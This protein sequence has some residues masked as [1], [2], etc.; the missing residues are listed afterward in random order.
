MSQDNDNSKAVEVLPETI[1]QAIRVWA[2]RSA[3][4][5]ALLAPGRTSLTYGRLWKQIENIVGWLNRM[6]IGRNDLVALMVPNGPEMA[7]AILGIASGAAVTPINTAF[8]SEELERIFSDLRIRALVMQAGL[9]SPAGDLARARSIQVVELMPSW[10]AEAGIFTLSGEDGVLAASAGICG[11]DDICR[12][13][14]T[15]G[16][17]GRPKIITHT[18]RHYSTRARLWDSALQLSQTDRC[19]NLMPLIYGGGLMNGLVATLYAGGSVVCPPA[20]HQ[21]SFFEWLEC[22]HP[23]YYTGSPTIHRAVLDQARGKQ[24]VI[25]RCPLRFIGATSAVLPSHLRDQLEAVFNA[26]VFEMYSS[27]E[28]GPIAVSPLSPKKR[29]PGSVGLP[30]GTEVAIMSEPGS[31]LPAG[32]IGEIVVRGPALFRG[33]QNDPEANKRSFVGGWFRMGDLGYLDEEGYL[34]LTGRLKEII[35]SGGQKVSPYEVN[36]ALLAHSAVAEAEAFAVPH[37][38]LGEEVAAAVVLR[39]GVVASERELREFTAGRLTRFKVPR[40]VLI[41]DEIPKSPAG[42]IQRARLAEWFGKTAGFGNENIAEYVRPRTRLEEQLAQIWEEVLQIKRVGVHDDFQSLGG[43]SIQATLIIGMACELFGISLPLDQFFKASTIAQMAEIVAR[44]KSGKSPAVS[45]VTIRGGGSKPPLFW[46]HGAEGTIFWYNDLVQHLGQDQPVY[47]VVPLGLNRT[48]LRP[49]RL[50]EMAARCILEIQALQPEG[51]YLLAG[52]SSAGVWAYE[53]A[54]Q[55]DS[56]GQKVG[57]V[58]MF[59]TFCPGYLRPSLPGRAWRLMNESVQLGPGP[60]ADYFLKIVKGSKPT[61]KLKYILAV[62]IE[63]MAGRSK[64]LAHRNGKQ[65]SISLPA[66]THKDVSAVCRL[67]LNLYVPKPYG[68]KLV[69]FCVRRNASPDMGSFRNAD[70][71]LGWR[72]LAAGG[73][74][75]HLVTGTHHTML[76]EPHA[77]VIAAQMK[78]HIAEALRTAPRESAGNAESVRKPGR[79]IRVGL[80]GPSDASRLLDMRDCKRPE[81]MKINSQLRN[82]EFRLQPLWFL[83][84]FRLSFV[85]RKLGYGRLPRLWEYPWAILS[86]EL[87]R[88]MRVLDVGSGGSAFPL[89]LN[90]YGCEVHATDPSLDNG[91]DIGSRG[92]KKRIQHALGIAASWGLPP[93]RRNRNSAITYVADPMQKLRYRDGHFDRIFC[94]SVIEHIP[95]HEWDHGL[96]EMARVLTD[97]GRLVMTLTMYTAQADRRWYEKLLVEPSLR[98]MGC[99]NYAT[100]ISPEDAQTRHPGQ[101]FETL[102][103]VWEKARVTRDSK[104]FG[105]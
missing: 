77:R 4:A 19:M 51:P 87:A 49:I 35:N 43:D 66:S 63:S 76:E 91:R 54:R 5:P 47:G 50:E 74:E 88:G 93:A 39:S 64:Q 48:R 40:R 53:I 89:L 16:T 8:G 97:G 14:R 70:A 85:H 58:A 100:P 44:A 28:C 105:S 2:E 56:K 38:R 82:L 96:S 3:E 18:H 9:D 36:E 94:I 75:T 26:P 68:G 95:V 79:M 15:S 17:T 73:V 27:T 83:P 59:D 1:P 102:G 86:A 57:L 72:E 80:D 92:W 10:D 46:L 37:P 24:E 20:F 11:P 34:F 60:G 30:A 62:A 23:T 12:L 98:L 67:A 29:K 6:G 61:R 21:S 52:P 99:I 90:K 41:V 33:Y 42:K 103:L 84:F 71:R 45:L 81:W 31:F 55:L 32:K 25:A 13:T 101:D 7:V 22:F 69:L 65:T 104:A 78:N